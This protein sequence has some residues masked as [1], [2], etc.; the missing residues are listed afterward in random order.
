MAKVTSITEQFQHF[1]CEMKESFWGELYGQT[2][3]AWKR[4]LELESERQRDLYSGWGAYERSA[5]G[6]RDYRNGYQQRD[7]VTRFGSIPCALRAPA[8]RIFC[9]PGL[10][11]FQRRAPELTLLIR[12]AFLR[13]IST[14]R[15]GRDCQ[16]RF[17]ARDG[18]LF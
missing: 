9:P 1:L 15:V 17:P 10:V 6:A 14:R 11:A 4:F 13:G 16:L 5:G 3:A 18:P 12:E 7:F 8:G 2:K